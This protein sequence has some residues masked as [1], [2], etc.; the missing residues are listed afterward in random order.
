MSTP[1][2]VEALIAGLTDSSGQPLA[3]GKIYTYEAGTTTPKTTWQ[4][5]LK[6]S[7]HANPIILDA[8]GK[9]L[10]FADGAYKFR[11]DSSADV[12]LY[13]H[14]NLLFSQ[15]NGGAIYGGTSTGSL[16]AYAI[17]LSPV[18][19][20]TPTTG[21][22]VSFIA[23]HTN[24]AGAAT[25]NLN[26]LGAIN[27]VKKTGQT[28][29]GGEILSGSLIVLQY[30]GTSWLIVTGSKLPQVSEAYSASDDNESSAS[31]NTMTGATVDVV[32][33]SG[34][35]VKVSWWFQWSVD[36]VDTQIGFRVE[37]EGASVT[38]TVANLRSTG[39]VS[40]T[41]E[42]QTHSGSVWITSPTTGT[43]VTY[44]LKWVRSAGA[45]VAYSGARYICAEVYTP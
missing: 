25:L 13:T 7:A 1:V 3:G 2:Q 29:S 11:I 8:Q 12:T 16:N 15:F 6:V 5:N 4:D 42:L 9:K 18:Q 14:D 10:V 40:N 32:V 27:I 37:E 21:Q 22:L 24:T 39:D 31:Y 20:S 45:N 23:N 35:I 38:D 28:P 17:S 34:D 30:N 43:A 26:G 33:R 19:L 44:D 41:G 36:N